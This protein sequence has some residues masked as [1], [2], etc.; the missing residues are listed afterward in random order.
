MTNFI[1]N[2]QD[3]LSNIL[4]NLSSADFW[5]AEKLIDHIEAQGKQLRELNAAITKRNKTIEKYECEK[6]DL[7]ER[8]SY[9]YEKVV[10]LNNG[11]RDSED[12]TW[13]QKYEALMHSSEQAICAL[14]KKCQE[15]KK[16]ESDAITI[17][18]ETLV[19]ENK[20]LKEK[21]K[22]METVLK[23]NSDY[24]SELEDR[25]KRLEAR[26]KELI[27]L[28][29]KE[30]DKNNEI[31]ERNK[32]LEEEKKIANDRWWET[33]KALE[34]EKRTSKNLNAII[35]NKN[36][37]LDEYMTKCNNLKKCVNNQYGVTSNA[38]D[39]YIS[40][41]EEENKKLKAINQ[42]LKKESETYRI[43]F[44]KAEC[45][46]NKAEENLSKIR[47]LIRGKE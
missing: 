23:N 11:I 42:A 4:E 7:Q 35:N 3:E 40:E 37:L 1:Y 15:Y 2:M 24:I 38:R 21:N 26:N 14:Q 34:D 12:L 9:L 6:K 13:K 22:N 10:E 19:K 28:C 39:G 47:D 44:I 20:E 30:Y 46:H 32:K 31:E 5:I 45:A 36:K 29:D 17:T 27:R 43:K 33:E 18:I 16:S 8:N 41:L 25:V